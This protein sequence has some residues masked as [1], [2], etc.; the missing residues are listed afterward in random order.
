M[1]PRNHSKLARVQAYIAADQMLADRASWLAKICGWAAL[2]R[3][4][5]SGDAFR[6]G[7]DG[8]RWINR[9]RGWNDRAIAHV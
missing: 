6:Q 2:F 8:R 1:T 7:A 9:E 5:V 4:H 3:N